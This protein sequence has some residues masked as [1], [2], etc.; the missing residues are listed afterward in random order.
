MAK[1]YVLGGRQ[2]KALL[3]DP[4][5]EWHWYEAA[6]I[7]EVDTDSGKVR[8]C[9]E[10]KSPLTVRASESS[11]VNFHSGAL[12][13]DKL[14]TCTTTEILIF[15]VPEFRQIG[16]ISLPCFN[17]L[18]HVVPAS[19]GNLLV[20]STGLDMVVKVSPAGELLREW[21]VV[22]EAPWTRFSRHIDYRKVETTKPHLSHPNF[23][24]E[25]N[26]EIWATRFTQRDAISLNG[27]K[28]RIEIA[29]EKPHDGVLWGD[30][31]VF[32]VVDGKLIFANRHTLRVDRIVDLRQIQDRNQQVLPAWCRGVL[33]VGD[34]MM[35][36]GFTRI[37]R[38]LFRENVR[39][40]K[41]VLREGTVVKPTH[42]ALF[43]IA[44]G[45][46]LKEFDLEPYG[47]NCVFGIFPAIDKPGATGP[48]SVA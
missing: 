36:V 23:V 15:Q 39:W 16:Y 20:V 18:H 42:I 1:L 13:G 2:R 12:I 25:L 35:W 45:V 8:T 24:F 40:A 37:R 48:T 46:C 9:V 27:S 31:L 26:N 41:M 10:Y 21:C 38:T 3:K 33:P 47:M 17:D 6:L 7:L 30:H 29:L 14:Y 32:T 22:D 19:D 4:I 43:D 28:S 11:S 34:S 5:K 44:E